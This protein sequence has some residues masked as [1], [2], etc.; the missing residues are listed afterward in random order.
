MVDYLKVASDKFGK[1]VSIAGDIDTVAIDVR[2]LSFR[3][4]NKKYGEKY[5][6]KNSQKATFRRMYKQFNDAG[7]AAG[8]KLEK[9]Y[10]NKGKKAAIIKRSGALRKPY[11]TKTSK[12][13]VTTKTK[14]S[15]YLRTEYKGE[16]IAPLYKLKNAWDLKGGKRGVSRQQVS[17]VVCFDTVTKSGIYLQYNIVSTFASFYSGRETLPR[18]FAIAKKKK[19]DYF[20]RLDQSGISPII[21]WVITVVQRVRF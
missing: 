9:A 12:T 7:R 3:E 17:L 16:V 5:K 6:T 15:R 19:D 21:N 1:W 14:G 18:L 4:F 10:Q 11:V 20:R 13:G 2:D 8:P